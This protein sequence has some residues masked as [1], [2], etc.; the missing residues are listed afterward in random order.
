M[1]K[2]MTNLSERVA[3]VTGGGTGIG[4]A[5]AETFAQQGARVV[6]NYSRSRDAAEKVAT[7]IRSRGG[8]AMAVA[9]DVSKQLEVSNLIF[10]TEREFGRLDY[11]INN[12]GW[13]K[14]VP[15]ANMDELTDDVWDRALN[16]NLRGAFNV[17][18]AAAPLLKRHPGA[19]IVNIAS[20]GALSGQ[21]SSMAYA[22]AKGGMV[23]MTKSLARALAPEVRVNAVLPGFVRTHF[24]GAQDSTYTHAERI[25]PLRRLATVEDVAAA[26]LFFATVALGTTG[27]TLVV[28]G[29]MQA[30][31]PAI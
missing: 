3:L 28:D 14:R 10:V 8:A 11:L 23:T 6:V 30:L 20:V 22:A 31:G 4:R 13:T 9:A 16:V 25:T 26:T 21:G 27:E 29:G 15:H 17:V 5:I 24:G 12:A 7:G 1:I 19:A 18:R 2:T